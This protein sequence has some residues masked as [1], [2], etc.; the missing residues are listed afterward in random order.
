MILIQTNRTV[1]LVC[2]LERQLFLVL[3]TISVIYL[4]IF[5][6]NYM[7]SNWNAGRSDTIWNLLTYKA[8]SASQG[9]NQWP[10]ETRG[11]INGSLKP[12]KHHGNIVSRSR[13]PSIKH[14]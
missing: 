6:V 8:Y 13:G 3:R 2:S 1:P 5:P 7:S 12:L 10:P 9:P 14:R 4:I 11:L